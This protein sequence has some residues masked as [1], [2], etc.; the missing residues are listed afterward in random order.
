MPWLL[1]AI[2]LSLAVV[3]NIIIFIRNRRK[4]FIVKLESDQKS[5]QVEIQN[6]VSTQTE[7]IPIDFNDVDF[8]HQKLKRMFLGD[9][10]RL[11]VMNQG[12][13]KV[14]GYIEAESYMTNL[15]MKHYYDLLRSIERIAEIRIKGWK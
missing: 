9:T 5:F 2:W 8:K 7:K 1:P 12:G 15:K 14:V 11:Q 13:Q 4:I 3:M 6:K 10:T